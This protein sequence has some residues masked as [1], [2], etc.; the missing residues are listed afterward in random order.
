MTIGTLF[1]V[2][3]VPVFYVFVRKFFKGKG[4]RRNAREAAT[5]A[6]LPLN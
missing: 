4:H 5:D 6:G 1:S 3:L 2:F